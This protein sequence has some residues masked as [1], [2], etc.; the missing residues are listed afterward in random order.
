MSNCEVLRSETVSAQLSEHLLPLV[1][2]WRDSD[3]CIYTTYIMAEQWRLGWAEKDDVLIFG[4]WILT[5]HSWWQRSCR[6]CL[7][8]T[9]EV[10]R[11]PRGRNA[12]LLPK[13]TF[14][15][16]RSLL[17]VMYLGQDRRLGLSTLHFRLSS[18]AS[19]HGLF[20]AQ[21]IRVATTTKP[22]Y[23]SPLHSE[24]ML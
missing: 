23:L 10:A 9:L 1:I 6:S 21:L 12:E 5:M 3:V 7:A 20:N 16:C 14:L 2:D 17:A 18:Q 11:P 4:Y 22:R 24:H 13:Q 19:F 8:L 15:A